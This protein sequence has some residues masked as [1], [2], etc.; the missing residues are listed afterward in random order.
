[1]KVDRKA[2]AGIVEKLKK[3]LEAIK[4]R[5]PKSKLPT[6]EALRVYVNKMKPKDPNAPRKINYFGGVLKL[7]RVQPPYQTR[8]DPESRR[9]KK[10]WEEGVKGVRSRGK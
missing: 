1:M 9:I 4:S 7:A 8:K 10:A 3:A 6:L 2:V 5:V